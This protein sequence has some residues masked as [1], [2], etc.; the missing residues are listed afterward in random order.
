MEQKHLAPS[1]RIEDRRDEPLDPMMYM[2]GPT[3]PRQ[4]L[5]DEAYV[6]D[7]PSPA[8]GPASRALG[9]GDIGRNPRPPSLYDM[10]Q[11]GRNLPLPRIQE[12]PPWQMIRGR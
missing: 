1:R 8:P 10:M 11:Q 7:P 4:V 12:S 6:S 5:T 9:V 3:D 2:P